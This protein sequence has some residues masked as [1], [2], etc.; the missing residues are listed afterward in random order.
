MKTILRY[1][2]PQLWRMMWGFTIKF[3]GTI[4]ELFL[5][6]ALAYMLDEI[7]PLGDTG[8]IFVWG[9]LMVL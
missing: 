1:L 5:P 8:R 2:R 4:C 7:V 6:W 3:I 9:G